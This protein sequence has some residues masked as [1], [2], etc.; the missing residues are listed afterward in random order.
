MTNRAPCNSTSIASDV[1]INTTRFHS[2]SRRQATSSDE[3]HYALH[4][5]GVRI[6]RHSDDGQE[7]TAPLSTEYHWFTNDPNKLWGTYNS[8]KLFGSYDFVVG[9]NPALYFDPDDYFGISGSELTIGRF[10]GSVSNDS[11]VVLHVT[12]GGVNRLV[13][14]DLDT[15]QETATVLGWID[16]PSWHDHSDFS[17]DGNTILVS[18]N[19]A[20]KTYWLLNADMSE[21]YPVVV[22]PAGETLQHGDWVNLG[23][24]EPVYV[25]CRDHTGAYIDPED[26]NW[27]NMNLTLTTGGTTNSAHISGEG[28]Y[29]APG[30][31][32]WSDIANN[33]DSYVHRLI[34]DPMTRAV[35]VY[36]TFN[37]GT[38]MATGTDVNYN[39]QPKAT[40]SPYGTYIIYG[41]DKSGVDATHRITLDNSACPLIGSSGPPV[42]EWDQNGT[43]Q[44]ETGTIYFSESATNPGAVE[45]DPEILNFPTTL[46]VWTNPGVSFPSGGYWDWS[47]LSGPEL[48]GTTGPANNQLNLTNGVAGST[49][50]IQATLHESDGT[51]VG[52]N[53]AVITLPDEE[54]TFTETSVEANANSGSV[55]LSSHISAGMGSITESSDNEFVTINADN[56]LTIDTAQMRALQET[57]STVTLELNGTSLVLNFK[58]ELRLEDLPDQAGGLPASLDGFLFRKPKTDEVKLLVV[59]DGQNI[60][61]DA[62][63]ENT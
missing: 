58:V 6:Y 32:L 41:N 9:G 29:R 54:S 19:G 17:P 42:D 24:G 39:G 31:S 13:S 38:V 10:E 46:Y 51:I 25:Y 40:L 33:Q 62:K 63:L 57:D 20:T 12:G 11:R 50:E 44:T 22:L 61:V 56:T 43:P 4:T 52:V 36:E 30:I 7:A 49:V 35:A 34:R 2:Y 59:A 18:S 47:Q 27:H 53:R 60:F 28:S 21:R 1:R 8:R 55:D 48:A 14:L 15:N 5:G 3:L 37:L 45:P 16:T 23:N 26:G